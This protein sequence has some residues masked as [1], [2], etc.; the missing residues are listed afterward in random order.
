MAV[1]EVIMKYKVSIIVPVYNAEKDLRECL[2]SLVNQTLKGIEIICI[3]DASSDN[4]LTIL[5]D[6][7]NRYNKLIKLLDLK[8]NAGQGNAMNHGLDAAQGEYIAFVDSDDYVDITM[9]EKLYNMAEKNGSDYIQFSYVNILN[10][11]F[12]NENSN[13][14]LFY[15]SEL[16]VSKLEYAL[17]VAN[18]NWSKLYHR[19]LWENIRLPEFIHQDLAVKIF[20]IIFARKIMYIDDPLYYYRLFRPGSITVTSGKKSILNN[21]LRVVEFI[22][23]ESKRLKLIDQYNGVIFTTISS[24][25]SN[26]LFREKDISKDISLLKKHCEDMS[27]TYPNYQENIIEACNKKNRVKLKLLFSCPYTLVCLVILK[28]A[29]RALKRCLKLV[30]K[31]F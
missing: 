30:R 5:K 10:K 22:L 19:R 25:I 17:N 29:V 15:Q 24:I 23:T 1:K 28:R 2:D 14:D 16:I 11:K 9:C 12:E 26:N 3:N 6:Y 31:I 4:S 7:K 8:S 21:H 27:K 20:P 13:M 18:N